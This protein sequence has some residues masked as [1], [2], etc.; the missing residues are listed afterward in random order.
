LFLIIMNKMPN[1]KTDELEVLGQYAE[2][3]GHVLEDEEYVEDSS[4][5]EIQKDE[6]NIKKLKNWIKEIK[7]TGET[8]KDLR[9][10]VDML[11]EI[12]ESEK[13]SELIPLD[14]D[15]LDEET[16]EIQK[17]YIEGIEEWLSDLKK[18]IDKMAK[19]R[20]LRT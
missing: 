14:G 3:L 4:E 13:N 8:H 1:Y 11:S 10:K 17:G 20:D 19:G 9:W 6:E 16:K 12:L 7:S 2:F 18:N 5:E 15:E